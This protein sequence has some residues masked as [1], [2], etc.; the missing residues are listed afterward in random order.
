L[1]IRKG[2]AE[3][4]VSP[5]LLFLCHFQPVLYPTAKK[6]SEKEKGLFGIGGTQWHV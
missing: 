6:N 2:L 5:F 1:L 3:K 4:S